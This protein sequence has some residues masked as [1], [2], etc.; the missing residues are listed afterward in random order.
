MLN[1]YCVVHLYGRHSMSFPLHDYQGRIYYNKDIITISLEM[2]LK[3]MLLVK[4]IF[5]SVSVFCPFWQINY[6]QNTSVR[7]KIVKDK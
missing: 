7:N 5:I 2:Y 4:F 6:T 3:K 1:K